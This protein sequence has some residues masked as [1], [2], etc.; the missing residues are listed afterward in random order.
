MAP[1]F[2]DTQRGKECSPG[3][4]SKFAF[5]MSWK[6]R[7]KVLR[8][9]RGR[10]AFGKTF[11]LKITNLH[12]PCKNP[13][14]VA[15][16]WSGL[17]VFHKMFRRSVLSSRVLLIGIDIPFYILVCFTLVTTSSRPVYHYLGWY[18]NIILY[19]ATVVRCFYP[20]TMLMVWSYSTLL[21][22]CAMYYLW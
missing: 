10:W 22:S 20:L 14:Q 3:V 12:D 6:L 5:E 21:H 18:S 16:H 15:I 8:R 1:N 4:P 2:K 19:F 9:E 7:E 17:G 13:W 11:L